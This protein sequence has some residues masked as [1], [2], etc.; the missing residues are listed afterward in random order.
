MSSKMNPEAKEKVV[1]ALRSGNY[2]QGTGQMFD[3]T[4]HC[5][6]GVICDVSGVSNWAIGGTWN[7][8]RYADQAIFPPTVVT[9]WAGIDTDTRVTVEGVTMDLMSHNDGYNTTFAQLADAIE[10]Q[11]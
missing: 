4:C 6:W 9:N 10:E 7:S 8:L 3:G 2:T 1:A 11:L 5:V